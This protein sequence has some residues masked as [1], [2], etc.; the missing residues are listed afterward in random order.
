VADGIVGGSDHK[1]TLWGEGKGTAMKEI[2]E[3]LK[4]EKEESEAR[5]AE[6]RKRRAE[7]K[8]GD[9]AKG[10]DDGLAWARE[11][12]YDDLKR[13]AGYIISGSPATEEVY[14]DII[15][16]YAPSEERGITDMTAWAKG[17]LDGIAEFWKKVEP[18]LSS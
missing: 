10:K 7:L 3:R 16:D 5:A 2:I 1:T 13:I 9:Y 17:W 8:T 6:V 18:H 14:Q 4:K 15:D 12:H 11:A